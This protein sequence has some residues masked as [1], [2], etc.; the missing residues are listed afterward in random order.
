MTASQAETLQIIYI[1]IAAWVGLCIGSFL[2]VV[3][4]RVPLMIENRKRRL[5][6]EDSG[7]PVE[8]VAPFNLSVPRSRCPTCGH[9]IR[10]FENIP[11]MSY[12][13]LGRRCSSCKTRIS[14]R[15]PLVEAVTSMLFAYGIW[16]FGIDM[17]GAIWCTTS[18]ALLVLA[19][20]EWD[21]SAKSSVS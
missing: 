20:M 8:A 10:W 6:S 5:Q 7:L 18:S 12:I 2:N 9:Q 16:K 13:V 3:V 21:K 11:V 4:Y 1:C 19:L 17:T 14:M 15:Y